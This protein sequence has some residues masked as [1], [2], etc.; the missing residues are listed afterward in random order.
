[1]YHR[2]SGEAADALIYDRPADSSVDVNTLA[3]REPLALT[4]RGGVWHFFR[5]ESVD[6][7][8]NESTRAKWAYLAM[9]PSDGISA[10]VAAGSGSGLFDIQIGP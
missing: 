4:G 9:E 5:V 7:Q 6:V 2:T 1:V 8:Y 10:T 3:L